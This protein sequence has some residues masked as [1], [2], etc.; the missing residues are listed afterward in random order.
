MS[1]PVFHR[2]VVYYGTLLLFA[3]WSGAVSAWGAMLAW[4]P[5]SR[6]SERRFQFLIHRQFGHFLRWLALVRA[7]TVE[8]R[9]WERIPAGPAVV[10]ANH[11]GLL[12]VGFVLARVPAGICIFKGAI[13][14]NL[15]FSAAARRAGYL[16]NDGALDLVRGATEKLAGGA[17]L[18]VFPEGTRT[19]PGGAIGPFRPGFAAIARRAGVPVQLIRVSCD[20]EL[21]GKRR[22]WWKLPQLPVRIVVQAGPRLNPGAAA[23]TAALVAEVEA[24]FR[25]S[26]PSEFATVPAAAALVGAPSTFSAS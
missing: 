21:L 6:R 15:L 5:A 23:S 4:L 11:P 8:Y 18:V 20:G 12:D 25:D 14:H 10:V 7:V 17:T 16:A 2:A 3:L 19:P 1:F 26:T 22:A 24:W 9:G 13:R